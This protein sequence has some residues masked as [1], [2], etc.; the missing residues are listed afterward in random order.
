MS[1]SIKYARCLKKVA[2]FRCFLNKNV[3]HTTHM[4]NHDTLHKIV[5]WDEISPKNAILCDFSL[6]SMPFDLKKS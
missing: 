3:A 4:T 6:K 5:I 1:E 2:S